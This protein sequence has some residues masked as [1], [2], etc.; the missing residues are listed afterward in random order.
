[1]TRSTL[2]SKSIVSSFK[3]EKVIINKKVRGELHKDL[4][5]LDFVL[6]RATGHYGTILLERDVISIP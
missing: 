5:A 3:G 6:Q 2:L 4:V 1:M